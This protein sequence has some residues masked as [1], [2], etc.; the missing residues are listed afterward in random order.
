[1]GGAPI[2][3]WRMQLHCRMDI[4]RVQ[5]LCMNDNWFVSRTVYSLMN[6]LDSKVKIGSFSANPLQLHSQSSSTLW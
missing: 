1:M 6:K 2:V 5:E 4:Q 3:K